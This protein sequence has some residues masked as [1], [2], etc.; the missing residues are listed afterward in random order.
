MGRPPMK[1]DAIER[2]ALELFVEKGV[3]AASIRDIAN[4]ASV[5]EGALYRHH[6]SKDDLVRALFQCHYESH[7]EQIREIEERNCSFSETIRDLVETFYTCHDED[8]YVFAFIIVVRHR[9]LDEVRANGRNPVDR[10][11]RIVRQAI[12]AGEIPDQDAALSTQLIVGMLSQTVFAHRQGQLEGPLRQH[13]AR[14]AECCL[15][16]TNAQDLDLATAD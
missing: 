12:E 14:V 15:A 9:L 3:D 8:P 4:R 13:A 11:E 1:R 10:I 5:T 16:I 6:R 2:S 7:D